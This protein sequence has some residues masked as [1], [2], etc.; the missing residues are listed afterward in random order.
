M[1]QQDLFIY[2][3]LPTLFGIFVLV[4]AGMTSAWLAVQI[5]LLVLLLCLWWWLGRW[6]AQHGLTFWRGFALLQGAG[7]VS[8]VLASLPSLGSFYL[9]GQVYGNCGGVLLAF[10]PGLSSLPFFAALCALF[11][12]CLTSVGYVLGFSSTRKRV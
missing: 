3:L 7:M 9:L 11:T 5:L 6:C 2:S 4:L 8:V 10:I 12:F 1:K